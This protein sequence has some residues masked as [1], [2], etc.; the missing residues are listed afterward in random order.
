MRPTL[1]ALAAR[2]RVISYSLAGDFG[3]GIRMDPTQG[4]EVFLAQIDRVLDRAG[5]ERTALC[6]V[7]YGG[8]IAACYAARR[9]SRVTKLVIASAPGPHWVPSARQARYAG[10]PWL[11][12]PA[13][14]ITAIERLGGEIRAALPDW[15]ARAS[16]M[17]RYLASVLMAPMLP[18]LMSERVRLQQQLD[19]AADCGRVT[20]PTLV[21]TGE[22]SL[23]RVVPVE[24]TR[25]YV[26]LIAGARYEMMKGTG[27]LGLLT[28]PDRFARIV[29]DFL[30]ARDS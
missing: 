18:H 15:R 23:D 12:V 10:R 4:F 24:S 2:H 11:S 19:C 27:H 8:I 3:T 21:I 26:G 9:P 25:E 28:Q 29:S 7:S 22:P 6:G 17:L 1:G 20:A 5:V 14:G 16:F 30:D 13:F